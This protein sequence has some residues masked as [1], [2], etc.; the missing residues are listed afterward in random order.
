[1]SKLIIDKS[2]LEAKSLADFLSIYQR[3]KSEFYSPVP[4]NLDQAVNHSIAVNTVAF[5][6]PQ[7]HRLKI[8][9]LTWGRGFTEWTNC[10]RTYPSFPH[11]RQPH[12]PEDLGFYDLC[13]EEVLE[14]QIEL[15]SYSGLKGFC[16]HYYSFNNQP[17]MDMPIKRF[18][19]RKN[20]QFK[21]MI[22]WANENWTKT[23]D[24]QS[25]QVIIPQQHDKSVDKN[26]I[27]QVL[28]YMRDSKYLK[29]KNKLVLMI[30]RPFLMI[31]HLDEIV[32]YW[33]E[34]I[35]K[36]KLGELL[37]LRSNFKNSEFIN[38][39][40]FKGINDPFD[41]I[42]Q[43]PPHGNFDK[44]SMKVSNQSLFNKDFV[45]SLYDY[46]EAANMYLDELQSNHLIYPGVIPSWD[47][48]ARR[49]NNPVVF[50]NSNPN[51]YEEWL[52]KAIE[53]SI[54]TNKNLVFI[55]AWNEWAEGA[56]I[57]PCS[58]YGYAHLQST[59]YAILK[60]NQNFTST[61]GLSS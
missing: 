3:G 13:N 30:Y 23:W 21:F 57:E 54:K 20:D 34:V 49:P 32:N 46:R 42:V 59:R 6:L 11:H 44:K 16:F 19:S 1:M 24:G 29:I 26:F 5:Y 45:G 52:S 55:N 4:L 53:S 8:N 61:L 31:D 22:C 17:I 10:T 51:V 40:N 37:L 28:P 41:G 35:T 2:T 47:N 12:L 56:H 58:W 15:A 60:Q 18:L 36:E 14:R 25:N 43:F 38:A 27:H 50:I 9:D 48:S 39:I 33:R 7:F